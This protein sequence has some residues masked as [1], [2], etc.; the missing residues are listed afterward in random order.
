MSSILESSV[1]LPDEAAT[2]SAAADWAK[3]VRAPL[4]VALHGD[5]GAGKTTFVRGVL[6]SLGVQGAIK[7]PTY[8][9]VESYDTAIG[10]VHHM[11]AYRIEGRADFESRG[12]L[13]YFDGPSVRLVEWPEKLDGIVRF[14]IHIFLSYDGEGRR[15]RIVEGSV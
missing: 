10:E 5:L 8:A 2:L 6:R 9:L 14:D 15:M 12:G 1:F 11:D 3:R 4:S 13:E 7:S